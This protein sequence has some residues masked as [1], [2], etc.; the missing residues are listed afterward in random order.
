MTDLGLHRPHR[1]EARSL[2]WAGYALGF[3]LGGFFDGILL[4]QILQWHHLLSG[5]EEA[6]HDIRVLILGDGLFHLLMYLIAGVGL[7][8][9][10]RARRQFSAPGADRLLL[11]NALIGFGAWHIVDAIFSHWLLGLHRIRMDVDNP[12]VWDLLWLAVFGIVPAVIGWALRRGGR[13]GS[14]RLMSSPLALAVAIAVAGP[15]AA[16]PP[17]GEKTVMVLFRPG[18]SP[19]QAL[20]AM[21]AVDGRLIWND[22]SEQLYALDLSQGGDANAL[23]GHGALLVSNSLLPVGCLSWI[24]T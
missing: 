13:G 4:H 19:V 11:A 2:H 18:V 6:R 23:Y 21:Q 16:L 10:W 8:L 15:I 1:S 14:P 9:L 20:A 22:P 12:L 7:W 3:A 24:R 5:I 17:P